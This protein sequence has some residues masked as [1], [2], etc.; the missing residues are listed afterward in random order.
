V[1]KETGVLHPDDLQK[2][3]SERTRMVAFPH[4]SNVI[5]HINPVKKITQ[6]AHAHGALSVVDGVG[7]APHEIP[8]MK[9]LGVDIY[10][11]SS[12]K[13]FGPH[14]GVMYVKG[15]LIVKMENQAHFF[16]EGIT[17]NMIT[18]AGPDHAQIATINGILDYFDALYER[19]FGPG[20]SPAERAR[21]LNGLLRAHELALLA[22][23]MAFLQG[24][25]DVR[26]VGPGMGPERAPIVSIVPKRKSIKEVYATLTGHKLMLGH[27]NF[28]AV[29]PLMDMGI[30]TDPGVIRLSFVHYTSPGEIDQLIAGLQRA[31]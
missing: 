19:H 24:R 17:R 14:L 18:P 23:L 30:A 22:P 5:G 4:C 15:S 2:L 16:K 25:D 27:G 31:L 8:D 9:D 11:F 7:W 6:M 13:T 26:I 3:F 12:Y 10:L 28:Y 29:R 20:G 21:A 1:D